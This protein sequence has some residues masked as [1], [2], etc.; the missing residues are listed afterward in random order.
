MER[1][2]FLPLPDGMVIGQVEITPT[3]LTVEVISTQPYAYCPACG[4]SSDAVHC[5]YRRTVHDVPCGGRSVVLRLGVRKF[6]CRTATCE[7]KVFAE[8]LPDVVQPWARISNRLLEELKAIGLAASAEVSERLAPR[9]GMKVKAPTL[10]CYLRSIAPPT[11]APVRVLGI[12]DF[13]IRRGDS[14]GTILVNLEMVNKVKSEQVLRR[15]VSTRREH[16]SRTCWEAEEIIDRKERKILA[17]VDVRLKS[18]SD[19]FQ[20]GNG[21]AL[22][23]AKIV[24]VGMT[25][26]TARS[27][28]IARL[29]TMGVVSS[30][31]RKTPSLPNETERGEGSQPVNPRARIGLQM[32]LAFLRTNDHVDSLRAVFDQRRPARPSSLFSGM[33]WSILQH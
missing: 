24:L 26:D 28:P 22:R 12:D 7:R 27:R 5:Q 2:P 9:L 4:K 17:R 13:A 15:R 6:F 25:A 8:R 20:A 1:S 23:H 30:M 21:Q 10:L 32:H 31:R 19:L 3:Q 33:E 16:Y 18:G 14:Y 11:D 29:L